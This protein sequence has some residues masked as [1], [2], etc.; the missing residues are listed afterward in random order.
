MHCC[1]GHV[2]ELTSCAW[3]PKD[4]Q[5]FIT[6]SADSTIRYNSFLRYPFIFIDIADSI[7]NVEN[8]RKQKTV[9][10]VKSKERGA[11][12]K[13]T[14]CG[15][16][17]D[18]RYIA[19]GTLNYRVIHPRLT[20]SL[21]CLDGALHLW[22]T[23]SNFVR[24][25]MTIQEAHAK[26]TE[27]GSLT[28]SVDGNT[29]LT[30]GGDHTVKRTLDVRCSDLLLTTSLVW[31]IRSFKRPVAVRS[32]VR[33]LYPST[34]A[35][36]SPDN[37]HVVTGAGG[38]EMGGHGALLFLNRQNLEVVK[39]LDVG[40]TPVVVQWHPKINQ[41]SY[42]LTATTILN[43]RS[44]LLQGSQAE[45]YAFYIRHKR[46]SMVPSCCSIRVPPRNPRSKTCRTRSLPPLLLFQ[47]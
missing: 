3:H 43:E 14:A 2:S 31:D 25:D 6:G 40:A 27:T 33:A 26:G 10:V 7:W 30:R 45:R 46:L 5:T 20:T 28:F 11:R 42:D 22:K 12:T 34:N 41:V 39:Q 47:V 38:S 15:Y 16:S 23:N 13:V 4:S 9:I 24:P 21:A 32:D 44:R 37:K 17:P 1:R 36:F 8:K 35:I 19:G 18:G 29:I